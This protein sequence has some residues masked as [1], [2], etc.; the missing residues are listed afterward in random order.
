MGRCNKRKFIFPSRQPG[1]RPNKHI[2]GKRWAYQCSKK[3]LTSYSTALCS[4]NSLAL[5]I[6]LQ[7]FIFFISLLFINSANSEQALMPV[8]IIADNNDL[9]NIPIIGHQ[10]KIGRED[11]TKTYLPLNELLEQQAGIDIQSVGG[12]GQFSFPT[13]RGSSGKQVLI[14]W[15]GLLINDLNGGSADIGSLSLSSAGNIDIYRGMS[16]VELSPTAVGGAINIQSQDLADNSGE[17]A[18]TIGS[19]ETEEW[20]AS[21]NFSKKDA[22]I[23]ININKFQ[24]ENNFQYLESKP[25]S[26][27]QN[28]AMESRKNNAV[29]NQSLLTKGHFDFSDSFRISASAQLQK[30]NREISSNINTST[31]N[32]ILKQDG[33]RIQTAISYSFL[34]LGNS[35][36]RLS[37]Q[38]SKELY[39]DEGSA[40][41]VGTQYNLYTTN[42]KSIAIQ[43][44][45]K[46]KK[47][48]FVVSSGIENEQVKTDFPHDDISPDDCSIGGKCE[49][50]FTRNAKHIGTRF[51]IPLLNPLNFML[52]VTRFQYSDKNYS[53]DPDEEINQESTSTTYDSGLNYQFTHGLEVYLKAGQQVRPASSSEL[54]G[55]KGTSK[56][57]ADLIAEKS[58]YSEIGLSFIHPKFTLDTNIYN[59]ILNDAIT[60]STDSRGIISFENAAKTE[61]YGFELTTSLD[62]NKYWTSSLNLTLQDNK[63][64]DHIKHAY[65]G[66]Q[67]GDYSR[68][69]SYF[70]TNWQWNQ[71]SILGSYSFQTGGYYN[72]LN[73]RPRDTKK[74]WNLSAVWQEHDW[75]VSLE[76]K[77]LTSDRAQ[78]YP[79][80]PEPGRQ[81]YIKFIYNW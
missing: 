19:F 57:N 17:A 1:Y 6:I 5:A 55:D 81:Y 12:N 41:G 25:V 48:S 28:P 69:H 36:L 51:N 8:Q 3:L 47:L 10:Q 70:S 42:K 22:S 75:L 44:E 32:A 50:D 72:S 52:Q 34:D 58:R 7:A 26:S 78:D 13:I 73:T 56:G 16:P 67:V 29:E 9:I 35:Q 15:D 24:S 66:N 33:H 38:K 74:E 4:N 46:F 53:N 68:F 54:F 18:I 31:N 62:W 76:G 23:F 60:P 2:L 39:D 80:I 21:H 43:H 45:I 77:N 14:F 64:V 61:H 63:I 30:N 59:R 40:V 20:Y 49:T 27:P 11:F 71:L 37:K 79:S 65:I